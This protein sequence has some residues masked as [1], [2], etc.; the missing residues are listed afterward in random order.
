VFVIS[1]PDEKFLGQRFPLPPETPVVIGRSRDAQ[2]SVGDVA[3]V[4]RHHARILNSAGVVVLEDLG[5]MNGTFAGN[6]RVEG[7]HV[8]MSGD[9]FQVGNVHFKLLRERDVEAAYHLAV[10][11]LMTRDGLTD[12]L[13][14]RIFETEALRECQRARRYTRALSLVLFDLDH[15]KEVNDTRGHLSGDRVL[16]AVVTI[17]SALMRSEQSL[18]RLGGEEFGVLCPETPLGGAL[19]LAERLRG[20]IETNEYSSATGP[21]WVTASFG[22]AQ[23][24]PDEEWDELYAAADAAC[25][26]SKANGRN[27]VTARTS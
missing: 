10:F 6:A 15:F 25:Y 17:A 18:A 5:S 1:H 11:E 2:I 27:R 24:Q 23:L 8:L 22:V 3:S 9:R 20:A 4:S 16:K 14:R 7:R 21:F 12:A 13:N 26:A 19:D